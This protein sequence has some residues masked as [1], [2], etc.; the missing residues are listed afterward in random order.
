MAAAIAVDGGAITQRPVAR[1]RR[2]DWSCRV[3]GR[4]RLMA[5]LR[6]PDEMT[7]WMRLRPADA[8]A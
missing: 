1:S 5:A 3:L 8:M 2:R 7:A 6:R 4:A